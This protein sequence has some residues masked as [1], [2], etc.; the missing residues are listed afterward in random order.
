[1]RKAVLAFVA[2]YAALIAV[3]LAVSLP[4]PE[5]A[6]SRTQSP[7]PSPLSTTPAPTSAATATPLPSAPG[8]A[9]AVSVQ[10]K[11]AT[12]PAEFRYIVLGSGEEFRLVLLDLA[13]GRAIE[14]ATAR[15]ALP[16]GAPTGP[17]AG[18]AASADGR[19]VLM[20]FDVPEAS[21]SLFVIRPESGD[22]KLLLRGEVR[23][24]A[25]SADGGRVAVG[26]NDEDPSLTGLWIGTPDGGMRRLVA[27]DPQSN[28]SP[29]VPYAFSPDGA[30]IAFGLGLG[31]SGRRAVI[32]SVSSKEGRIDRTAGDPLV[33]GADANVVGSATG[34]E[35]RSS[36]ELF[37]WSSPTMFGG[38]SG[39]DLYD[40]A[41]KRSTSL[42]RPATGIQLGA[43]AWRPNA[44]QYAT[45]ERP[46]SHV[47][48]PGTAWLRGQDG[49]AR[50]LGDATFVGDLW[51]SRDGSRL[52]ALA[53]GD[54][55]VGGVIDLLTG[56][57]AMQYCKR[58]GG[59]PP[60]PCT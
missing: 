60:A 8:A 6:V 58:G 40:L 50:M 57:G 39:A 46:E 28:G 9:G 45:I 20:T 47:F 3:A 18:A 38:P 12:V 44:A 56:K 54:D 27:D 22:A 23:G 11:R 33:V 43:A 31:D 10:V 1:M 52:F 48:V 32:M 2:Y 37:V 17:S 4:G 42:Y 16:P 34:G 25:I 7:S 59:P 49:S 24:V 14:V 21:D 36:R 55:S 30:I 53:G 19:T 26:R 15:I 5:S 29:P 35:F 41:T 13:A 51:W